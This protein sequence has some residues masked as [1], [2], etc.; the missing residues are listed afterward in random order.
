MNHSASKSRIAVIFFIVDFI[1]SLMTLEN[2]I[3]TQIQIYSNAVPAVD[4]KNS[5][6]S[7]PCSA[8]EDH[9]M[10]TE[11]DLQ[12]PCVSRLNLMTLNSQ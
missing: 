5:S 4:W 11:V 8:K 9:N 1:L 7:R 2:Y 3:E 12:K 6:K 10:V